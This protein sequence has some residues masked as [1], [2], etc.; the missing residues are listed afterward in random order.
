[1]LVLIPDWL[2][3][4]QSGQQQPE[5]LPGNGARLDGL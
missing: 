1:M 3:E 2:P 5:D 4:P